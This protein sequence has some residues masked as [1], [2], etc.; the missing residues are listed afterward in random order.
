MKKAS[1]I[2]RKGRYIALI[3]SLAGLTWFTADVARAVTVDWTGTVANSCVVSVG[4]NGMLG[5]SIDGKSL[6]SDQT[7]AAPAVVTVMSTSNNTVTFTKP[8]MSLAPV[9]Y[10]G[11]P[12]MYTKQN[13][14]KGHTNDWQQNTYQVSVESGDTIFNYHARAEDS[15]TFPMGIYR[16]SSVVTCAPPN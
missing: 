12:T 2:A 14:N 7:A 8:T 15:S 3:I 16:M 4:S 13:S 5:I 6:S 11:A 1:R 9:G 10:L